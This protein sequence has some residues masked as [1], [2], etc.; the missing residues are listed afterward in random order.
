MVAERRFKVLVVLTSLCAEGTPVLALGMCRR[1]LEWGLEPTIVTLAA[2]PKDLRGEFEA[3]GLP[4][5]GLNLASQGYKGYLEALSALHAISCR[6]RPAAILSFPLGWHVPAAFAGRAA[7][8]KTIVAHVGNFPPFW[9][10]PAFGKFRLLMD[11][12]RWAGVRLVCCSRYVQDGVIEHF[13]YPRPL[14]RMV[15]N[16]CDVT[17]IGKRADEERRKLV[18]SSGTF[19]VGM[20]ARLEVHKDQ[21]V[22]IR[23]SE[24]LK[25]RGIDVAVDLVGGGSRRDEYAK[26]AEELGMTDRICLCGTR[27]DVPELLASWDAFV[28]AAKR[29]EG[30]GIALVESMAAGTPIVATDVGACREV[31]VGG[32]LGLLAEET[33]PESM[34]DRIQEIIQSP[35]GAARRGEAARAY[36]EANFAIDKMASDYADVLELG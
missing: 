30:F 22:L 15:Y 11:L 3:A 10:G 28:F 34:A 1:W 20:V 25:R 12:G 27:R 35:D 29:D 19:R 18:R 14:T 21:P 4:L 23:A 8:V 36:A 6:L 13:R 2:E 26:L 5:V 31:L 32:K 17:T 16:A 9:A 33:S 24:I 7:G